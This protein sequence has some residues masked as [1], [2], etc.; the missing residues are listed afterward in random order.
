MELNRFH[1]GE[2]KLGWIIHLILSF[3]CHIRCYK[4]CCKCLSQAKWIMSDIEEIND[5]IKGIKKTG[6]STLSVTVTAR[7][8]IVFRVASD[9]WQLFSFVLGYI[10]NVN[11]TACCNL[12]GAYYL[13]SLAEL[14]ALYPYHCGLTL[15][16]LMSMSLNL[17]LFFVEIFVFFFTYSCMINFYQFE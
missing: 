13:S 6:K 4:L 15:R 2:E 14:V 12:A 1:Q 16:C 5:S 17:W 10:C 11:R 9:P 7:I 8:F 3:L